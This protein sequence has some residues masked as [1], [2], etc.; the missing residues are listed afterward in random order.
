M[1]LFDYLGRFLNREK[2]RKFKKGDPNQ[3]VD[4]EVLYEETLKRE[5][6]KVPD[7]IEEEMLIHV[8]PAHIV[9]GVYEVPESAIRIASWAFSECKDLEVVK[10]H[11][12]FR[13]ISEQAFDRCKRLKRVE[14]DKDNETMKTIGGFV[15]CESL[16]TI[17]IPETVQVV[18]WSAFSGCKKLK[19]IKLPNSCWAIS[20]FAFANCESLTQFK[21]PAS[22]TLVNATAFE[23]C[24]N[25]NVIF[26]DY[27]KYDDL[28]FF[29]IELEDEVVEYPAGDVVI[30][31][32]ALDDVASVT[33]FDES[34]FS[35]VLASGY[36]GKIIFA[37]SEEE[38]AIG[39]DLVEMKKQIEQQK[40]LGE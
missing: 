2:R 14:I 12:D 1:G 10:L 11:K 7:I 19:E 33:C 20:P 15:G 8:N 28:G 17:E 34:T 36:S 6:A 24:F 32:G 30:E 25:L 27:S 13:Y 39:I 3:E 22:I 23:G 37:N 31:E 9:N 5:Q 38:N 16:E 21:M 18:G 29:D 4:L 40:S 35:K 26:S